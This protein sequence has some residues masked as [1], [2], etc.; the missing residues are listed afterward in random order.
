[1]ELLNECF[2]C[3]CSQSRCFAIDHVSL[4]VCQ[5][6]L[7]LYAGVLCAFVWL[8][9]T[10]VWRRGL[11]PNGVLAL[12]VATLLVAM[13][14]GLHWL[15]LGPRWRMACGLWTGH[16]V[17]LWLVGGCAE[18]MW[19]SREGIRR[20]LWSRTLTWA[21]REILQAVFALPVLCAL[22]AGFYRLEW[23]GWWFWSLAATAGL[24]IASLAVASGA[25][26]LVVSVW[27]T[28][29]RR[30]IDGSDRAA[31]QV[32]R[33]HCPQTL[34]RTRGRCQNGWFTRRYS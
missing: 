10:G 29:F 2:R 12:H 14:G 7:G 33:G 1:M 21:R 34:A 22:A 5:R 4:P 23:L 19:R 17:T 30:L 25:V 11:A 15:D 3:V 20:C 32:R 28:S 9:L 18:Q 8:L 26:V 31:G 13:A 6:C 24:A 27:P 16:V